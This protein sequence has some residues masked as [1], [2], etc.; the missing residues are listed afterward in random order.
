MAT[1]A[2]IQL[3]QLDVMNSEMIMKQTFTKAERLKSKKIISLLFENGQSFTLNTC[4]TA[5]RVFHEPRFRK[6]KVIL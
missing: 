4:T 3:L 1:H 2:Q 6:I 5:V